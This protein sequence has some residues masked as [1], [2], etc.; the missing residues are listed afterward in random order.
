[1]SDSASFL[2]SAS[3]SLLPASIPFRYFLAA[4]GF[5]ILAWGMLLFGAADLA[6][7]SGG[8]GPVLGA[9]HL[10]T[11]G[12][13]AMSVMGAS[14]QLL[15]VVTRRPLGS[16]WLAR[17]C[18]WLM[19]PGVLVLSFGFGFRKISATEPGAALVVAGLAVFI[20]LTA[21][22]LFRARAL[23]NIAAHG[24]GA[25]LAL[26]G[27]MALA[28]ALIADYRSGFLGDHA[29]VA[30]LHMIAAIFGFMG[31][32]VVGFSQVLIPMFALSRAG[33]KGL[34]W[35]HLALAS[36][37]LA[38]FAVGTLWHVRLAID[39]GAI[40]AVFAAAVYLWLMIETLRHAMR[41]RLGISF[42]LIK[43]SWVAL[44]VGLLVGLALTLGADIPN[45]GPLFGFILLVGWLLT[46]LTGVLQRIM[47]FLASMHGAKSGGKPL[48]LSDLTAETP[49]N[50]HAFCHLSA[51]VLIAVG[52]V[53]DNSMILLVGA[54]LGLVSAIAF[55]VF[56]ALVAVRLR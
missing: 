34:G 39:L 52:I 11:L 54:G 13:L 18:F 22:N 21:D 4:A 46:F 31:L 44:A 9:I 28:G 51:V 1:M 48:L 17:L 50:I 45:G 7:F 23:G 56:G 53:L 37:A 15:P 26:L 8:L 30:R 5:Y 10:L 3:G 47:P 16:V 36:A 12:V 43:A 55:G 27:V 6:T 35:A 25:L 40:G 20:Y 41:K 42:L 33:F 24:W 49:L 2:G 29:A 14:L 19:L 32:L 38:V